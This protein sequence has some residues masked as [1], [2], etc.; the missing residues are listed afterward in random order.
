MNIIDGLSL[1]FAKNKGG[2]G[3]G[4]TPDKTG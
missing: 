2:S 1:I 3:G 4:V